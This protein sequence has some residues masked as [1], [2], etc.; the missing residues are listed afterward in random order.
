MILAVLQYIHVCLVHYNTNIFLKIKIKIK[1]FIAP[2]YSMMSSSRMI[3]EL[4]L[5]GR[6]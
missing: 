2:T 5:G 4:S 3:A 1:I 6:R